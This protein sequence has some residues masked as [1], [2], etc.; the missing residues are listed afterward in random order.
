MSPV[1]RQLLATA[2][3]HVAGS[4]SPHSH[5]AKKMG[6]PVA[7]SAFDM[8]VYRGIG[9]M[10]VSFAG[11]LQLSY[12]KKSTPHDAYVFASISSWPRPPGPPPPQCSVPLS[13]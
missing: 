12:F 3:P 1:V 10:A 7:L 13:L 5:I 2:A 6:R 9:P 4:A 8:A 11:T